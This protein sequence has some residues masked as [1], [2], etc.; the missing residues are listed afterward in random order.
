M[1]DESI[2]KNSD[3]NDPLFREAVEAIDAGNI[4][5]LK[6]LLDQ[7]PRLASQRLDVPREGYFQRPYLLWFVADNPIRHEELPANIV[8]IARLIMNK[9]HERAP[10][11]FLQQISYACGLASTGSI[12]K[13]CGVQIELIDLFLDAGVKPGSGVGELAHGNPEAA[14]HLIK[15]GAE[16]TL[17]TAVGLGWQDE[18]A[19]LAQTATNSEMQVAL[20]VAAFFG[21]AET[22][23]FLIEKGIDVNAVPDNF[24][25]FHSHASAL[26]QA[27]FS[28]LLESV[29]LLVEA[30]ATLA[31]D[32]VYNATP[33]DWAIYMQTT[34]SSDEEHKRRFA[35]IE[36]YLKQ[37]EAGIR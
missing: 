15:R 29:K 5:E 11:T 27:V 25:G 18:I 31:T 17:P 1:F 12:P 4:N 24:H 16:L 10:D 13:K 21:K 23:S 2:M 6:R 37:K 30:G 33:L 34:G 3:I 26:H 20:L 9:V 8:E 35:E 36:A 28:G 19:R 7:Y 14:E 32:R 22:I